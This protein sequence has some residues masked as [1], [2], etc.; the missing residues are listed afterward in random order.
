MTAGKERG[1]GIQ[2]RGKKIPTGFSVETGSRGGEES[3]QRMLR[4]RCFVVVKLLL[5]NSYKFKPRI[6][7]LGN[8][9]PKKVLDLVLYT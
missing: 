1:C 4:E 9:L 7:V 5:G 2:R 6:K 8:F 3:K